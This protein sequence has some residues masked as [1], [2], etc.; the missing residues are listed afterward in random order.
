MSRF[1]MEG[2]C[3]EVKGMMRSVAQ[4]RLDCNSHDMSDRNAEGRN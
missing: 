1:A 2:D 3:F 4:R